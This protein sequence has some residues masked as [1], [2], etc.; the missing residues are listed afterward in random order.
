MCC[1]ALPARTR[2]QRATRLL[3]RTLPAGALH[4]ALWLLWQGHRSARRW[5]RRHGGQ[6]RPRPAGAS[7]VL[8]AAR[9]LRQPAQ[10]ARGHVHR[11]VRCAGGWHRL[12]PDAGLFSRR[13]AT[14]AGGMG[15]GPRAVGRRLRQGHHRATAVVVNEHFRVQRG[16]R[17]L[18]RQAAGLVNCGAGRAADPVRAA[19]V[20]PVRGRL[21][22]LRPAAGWWRVR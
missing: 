6:P 9:P 5:R 7:A 12:L 3:L 15:R 4:A 11:A 1:N 18:G 19:A 8:R 17:L 14:E 13:A 10:R 2:A 22:L 21:T 16:T 20:A